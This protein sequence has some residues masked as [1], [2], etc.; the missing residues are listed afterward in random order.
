MEDLVKRKREGGM[1][2]GREEKD[3]F[4]RCKKTRSPE[5]ERREERDREEEMKR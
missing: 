3:F 4:R 1:N 2:R 5:I